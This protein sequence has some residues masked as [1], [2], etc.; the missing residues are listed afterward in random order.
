MKKGQ[1]VSG[2]IAYN[3]NF[4]Y[5]RTFLFGRLR[6]LVVKVLHRQKVE[7][8]VFVILEVVFSF[9]RVAKCHYQSSATISN[10][11]I[12]WKITFGDS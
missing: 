5:G 11:K 9:C 3:H 10:S 1:K 2:L 4:F 6:S 12:G 7:H 8:A